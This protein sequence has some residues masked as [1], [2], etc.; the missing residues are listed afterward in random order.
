M[1]DVG[2]L[3]DITRGVVFAHTGFKVAVCAMLF[4]GNGFGMED[5]LIGLVFDKSRKILDFKSA[6]GD[7]FFEAIGVGYIFEMPF[8]DDAIEALKGAGDLA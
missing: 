7:E 2:F 8:K 1:L 4:F 5:K 6:S 3:R